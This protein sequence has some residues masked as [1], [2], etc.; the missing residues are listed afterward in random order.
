MQATG[1]VQSQY[2]KGMFYGK[3]G[4]L[5]EGSFWLLQAGPAPQ[6]RAVPASEETEPAPRPPGEVSAPNFSARNP[7]EPAHGEL[8]RRTPQPAAP[9][10]STGA[11][12]GHTHLPTSCL[13]PTRAAHRAPLGASCPQRATCPISR[14][15]AGNLSS[16]C[17]VCA[18]WSLTPWGRGGAL[19]SGL[20]V[21]FIH[22]PGVPSEELPLCKSGGPGS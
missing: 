12:V 9:R 18:W 21:G 10:A 4:S 20:T 15:L 22:P 7:A 14:S 5:Y 3:K 1:D 16:C 17:F 19:S 2:I 11:N 6:P 13:L 8:A